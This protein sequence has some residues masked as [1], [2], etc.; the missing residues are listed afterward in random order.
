MARTNAKVTV[1]QRGRVIY[2][3]QVPAGPFRIQDINE[4][5]SGDLHVKIEEQSGQVQE[6][7]VS[8][9]S[10][11]FLT[12]PGQVRYKLAAGATAGLGSQYGRRLF[13]LSRSLLGDR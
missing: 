4:T 8:T 5:V 7:D 6:Y 11:P 10:I 2:E 1:T 9:A 3:S 13:H 12:R